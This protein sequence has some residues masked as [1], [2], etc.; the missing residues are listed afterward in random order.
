MA[1]KIAVRYFFKTLR[2]LLTPFVLLV[3]WL[4][5]P[6]AAVYSEAEKAALDKKTATLVLYQYPSCPFCIKVRRHIRRLGLSIELENAQHE[7]QARSL[8]LKHGGK[9]QVPCLRIIKDSTDT[10][11]KD[12]WLY[13]SDQIIQYLDKLVA[14]VCFR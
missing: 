1:M 11:E 14:S 13:E 7:G 8:L 12:T 3:N 5:M 9:T 2:L 10:P 6:K 4:T